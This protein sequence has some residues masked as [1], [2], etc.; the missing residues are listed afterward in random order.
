MVQQQDLKVA[1]LELL[2]QQ[3]KKKKIK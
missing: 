3:I 1:D 2:L